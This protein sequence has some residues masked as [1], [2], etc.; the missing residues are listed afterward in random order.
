[1]YGNADGTCLVGNGTRNGL[2]NPPRSISAELVALTVIE[3]FNGFQQSQ[4]AFLN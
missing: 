3:F 1:M 2:A 4:V